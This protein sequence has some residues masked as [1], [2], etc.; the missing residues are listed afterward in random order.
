MSMHLPHGRRAPH[1]P[2][3]GRIL[4]PGHR[5]PLPAGLT[6]A[7]PPLLDETSLMPDLTDPTLQLGP[8]TDRP[9]ARVDLGVIPALERGARD[10]GRLPARVL[11]PLTTRLSWVD[12]VLTPLRRRV[13]ECIARF[14]FVWP[15]TVAQW[16]ATDGQMLT[17]LEHRTANLAHAWA[18]HQRAWDEMDQRL[19]DEAFEARRASQLAWDL[20]DGV[21]AQRRIITHVTA[22]ATR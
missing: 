22:G 12:F 6:P 17:A 18:A 4:H 21:A 16:E 13:H 3:V 11:D 9:T 10:P 14:D 20:H 5:P 2:L 7:A 15:R 8:V 19:T 1:L